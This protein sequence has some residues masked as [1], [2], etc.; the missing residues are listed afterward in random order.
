MIKPYNILFY[1]KLDL[2]ILYRIKCWTNLITDGTQFN[3]LISSVKVTFLIS[4]TKLS[5]FPFVCSNE[6]KRDE[7]KS[8]IF[9]TTLYSNAVLFTMQARG[10]TPVDLSSGILFIICNLLKSTKVVSTTKAF[11]DSR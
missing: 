5:Y 10:C 9:I 7:V 4:L 2:N 8:R 6:V 3:L 11:Y 1:G